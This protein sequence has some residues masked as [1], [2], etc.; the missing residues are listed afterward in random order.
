[1]KSEV[2]REEKENVGY[3]WRDGNGGTT[4]ELISGTGKPFVLTSV[5]DPGSIK[6]RW[7][8]GYPVQTPVL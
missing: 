8:S 3:R 1:M 6:T 4:R 5:E 7:L 2:K